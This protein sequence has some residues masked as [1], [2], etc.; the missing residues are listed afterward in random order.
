MV[1][2]VWYF[3]HGRST[4]LV[5]ANFLNLIYATACV[6]SYGISYH[7]AVKLLILLVFILFDSR[8]LQPMV[9]KGKKV[10]NS[11]W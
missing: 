10:Y 3:I 1:M 5:C 6:N 8:F 7:L 2:G 4:F 9:A 11:R